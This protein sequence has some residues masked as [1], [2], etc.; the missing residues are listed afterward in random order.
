MASETV[1][2]NFSLKFRVTTGTHYYPG[3]SNKNLQAWLSRRLYKLC[4][5]IASERRQ[6]ATTA[7]RPP[8]RH[9]PRVSPFVLLSKKQ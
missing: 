9:P 2:K 1:L 6:K 5:R 4:N 8:P 7:R 3:G